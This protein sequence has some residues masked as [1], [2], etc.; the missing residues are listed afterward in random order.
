M[1]AYLCRHPEERS[2]EDGVDLG[3]ASGEALALGA[4]GFVVLRSVL[5]DDLKAA[6]DGEVRGTSRTSN[7]A[8]QRAEAD[9]GVGSGRAIEA[10]FD[11]DDAVGESRLVVATDA[12]GDQPAEQAQAGGLTAALA[13]RVG[14]GLGEQGS[15]GFAQGA[16]DLRVAAGPVWRDG[17]VP[18][19]FIQ[20][21]GRTVE[22]PRLELHVV[23]ALIA[24]VVLQEAEELAAEGAAASL[25][26][27]IHPL[28]LPGSW[29]KEMPPTA[30]QRLSDWISGQEKQPA[31]WDELA[32]RRIGRVVGVPVEGYL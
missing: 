6:M 21:E 2:S 29:A 28:D 31:G 25:R 18:V 3:D 12:G 11:Q 5:V 10:A 30:A 16:V 27:N 1:T 32:R 14:C 4:E 9:V 17:H 15:E 24:S 13:L 7:G 26:P 8:F 20:R 23:K 22:G 19:R